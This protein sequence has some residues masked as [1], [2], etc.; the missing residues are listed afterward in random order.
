[1]IGDD[2]NEQRHEQADEGEEG[3]ELV[4]TCCAGPLA[5]ALPGRV[6]A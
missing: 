1:M 6:G 4:H 5:T 2:E 3:C